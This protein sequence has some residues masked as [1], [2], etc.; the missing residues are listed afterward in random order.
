MNLQ[1]KVQQN[2]PLL[3]SERIG[4]EL[5][6]YFR[7]KLIYKRW[8]KWKSTEKSAS[9]IINDNGYPNEWID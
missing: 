3:W 9:I 2:K 8:Y 1:E 5:Y 7:G 6:V 4:H